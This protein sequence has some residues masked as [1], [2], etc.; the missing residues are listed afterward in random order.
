L[1]LRTVNRSNFDSQI[2]IWSPLPRR[3]FTVYPPAFELGV[4][5]S[6]SADATSKAMSLLRESRI[7]IQGRNRLYKI[8]QFLADKTQRVLDF[9]WCLLRLNAITET[10]K[11]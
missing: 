9:G 1:S 2:P 10:V 7:V 5:G 4:L 6:I 8:P 3:S 11:G